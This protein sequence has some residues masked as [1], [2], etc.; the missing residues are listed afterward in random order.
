M[1]LL[2]T[3][4]NGGTEIPP[5]VADAFQS[6]AARRD[7]LSPQGVEF[8][9][10]NAARQLAEMTRAPL[11]AYK[12]SRLAID[13][14]RSPHHRHLFSK[15]TRQLPADKRAELV[16]QYY[17][18]YRHRV[19]SAIEQLLQSTSQ[20]YVIHVAVRTFP[21]YSK[22]QPRRTDVG[23]AYDPCREDELDLCMDWYEEMF[24]GLPWLRVRR[25]YPFRGTKDGLVKSLREKFSADE[26][27]G[28]EIYLNQAWAARRTQI[29]QHSLLGIGYA[30]AS[31]LDLAPASSFDA[32]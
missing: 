1:A 5:P 7:R 32:A 11:V 17:L 31:I 12:Y 8:G 25:N 19:Q 6:V 21:L 20:G 3:C 24:D 26:Y 27:I 10:L 18:P 30:L 28:I 4:E 22:S 2:I 23:L 16:R 14:N 13:V 29:R 15:T 9:A